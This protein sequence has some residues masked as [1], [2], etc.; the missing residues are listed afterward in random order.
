MAWYHRLLNTARPERLS[1]D[2]DRELEFHLAERADELMAGGMGEAEARRQARLRFGGAGVQ[3]ERT[4]ERDVLPW[5]ESLAA[6]VRYA[7]RSLRADPGFAGVA[8]LSLGL[9]LGIGANTAIFSLVDAVMLRPLPVSR[10]EELVQVTM[11]AG[12]EDFTNPLWEELRDRQDVFAGAFATADERF[13][14]ASGGEVRP[15]DGAWVSGGFFGALGVA[16]CSPS[17]WRS[18]RRPPCSSGWRRRGAPRG[19]TRTRPCRPPGAAWRRGTRA[20]PWGGRWWWGRSRCR[21]CSCWAPA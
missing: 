4:R 17:P 11:G 7:L 2:L 15:V 8:V 9:G 1:R 21:W 6:D 14:L 16:V 20:S 3:K 18:R 5:L 12:A 13:D 10:P 19:W